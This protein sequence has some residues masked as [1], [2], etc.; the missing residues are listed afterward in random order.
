MARRVFVDTKWNPKKHWN[1]K[2]NVCYDPEKDIFIEVDSLTKPKE[3]DEVYLDSSLFPNMWQQLR[4]LISNGKKVY[5]FTRPWKWKEIRKRFRE[6]LKAKTGRV[7]KSDNSDAYLLWRVYEP[8][9]AKNNTHRYFKLLTIV[10]VEMRA[11]FMKEAVLYKSLQRIQQINLLN[12]DI[13]SNVRMLEKMVEEVRREIVDKAS[14]IIPRFMDIA[15][16]LGLNRDDINGLI[17]LAGL[18]IYDKFISYKKSINYFGLYKAKGRDGR[19]NKKYNHKAQRHLLMLTNAILRKNDEKHLP[20]FKDMKR[21]L[22][23]VIEVK[24]SVGS[25]GTGL[26]Y[27]PWQDP[28]PYSCR[29]RRACGA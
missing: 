13:G 26:G 22:R 8:S 6:D 14:E 7:S 15:D 16:S 12:V 2:K 29:P 4:K 18:L 23:M 21:I 11:L 5:Y 17:G 9:L 24:R 10:D 3:Y 27:K 20:T 1:L 19:K 25:L 28:H